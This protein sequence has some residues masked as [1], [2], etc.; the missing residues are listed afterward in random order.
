MG[1]LLDIAL[2]DVGA[3]WAAGERLVQALAGGSEA[4][5]RVAAAQAGGEAPL[6][7]AGGLL[8]PGSTGQ[9]PSGGG[10]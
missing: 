5:G 10:T 6:A 9:R 1:R 7:A 3:D 8:G 4:L 2:D